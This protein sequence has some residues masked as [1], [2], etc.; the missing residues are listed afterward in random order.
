M[1]DVEFLL[2]VRGPAFT[3]ATIIFCAGIVVR[4]LEILLM[5]RKP[6]LAEAR[7][8]AM[9]GGVGTML[10]RTVPDAGTLKRS[11]LTIITGWVYHV[12]LFVIIFLF[13][14]HILVFERGL[15]IS[16][17]G[18]P[19]NIV[20]A[21]TVVTIFALLVALFH[22]LRDPVLR[23]LSEF[24]DYLVWAVT[25]LPVITGWL[26]F[27]RVGAPPPALIAIHILS[28]ELLM[29]LFPFTKLSHAFT[30]WMARWY[31]GAIAGYRGVKS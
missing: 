28:V 12:G 13:V 15:G 10:R 27:H 2:W 20:D 24:N 5:G 6:E 22:R 31:N 30:L 25:F 7:G 14:P 23:L 9:A 1:T 29:V 4:I 26:A 17:P 19:T 3:T 18:L 11:S 21:V 8:S 16:W